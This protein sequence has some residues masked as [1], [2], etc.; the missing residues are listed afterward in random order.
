M[1][2][3]M[4][5]SSSLVSKV[6]HFSMTFRQLHQ[7]CK[8]LVV[9][10]GTAGC[11]MAAKLSQKFDKTPNHVIVIE[12]SEVHYY[13]PLFT[14]IGGG[15]KDLE[16]S[17]KSMKSVLPQKAQWIKDKVVC[18][19]PSENQV[20]TSNGDTI[21]YEYMIVAMGMDLYWDKL[22]GLQEA[23]KDPK[24]QVCSI[25]GAHTVSKVFDKIKNVKSG[26]ALFTFPNT[27][28]KCPGAPQKIVYLAEEFWSKNGKRKDVCIVYNTS[29]PVIFGVKKYADALWDVCKRRSINVNLRSNLIEI[30]PDRKEAVFEDLDNSDKKS[31]YE[32]SLLHVTPPMGTPVALKQNCEL[33]NASGFL[34][35]NPKTLQH[36][37]YNNIYGLGDCT[38]T[39]NS[40][41]M[42]AIASQSKVLYN[43]LMQRIAGEEMTWSYNGYASCPLVTGPGKCILA[44]F[45][46]NLTPTETF[47]FDQGKELYSMY[48]LKKDVFPFIYWN[49]MVKGNWNGP[50]AY[51]KLFS[52]LKSKDNVNSIINK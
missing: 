22:P 16:S 47:P 37:R 24:S 19:Q 2:S 41:T 33:T 17:R 13:Q 32:Y 5:S 52:L 1:Y 23:L 21:Q 40:K 49:L 18:F 39:P 29:L 45:D 10:G 36:I 8:I 3:T 27:P 31:T 6:Q 43:N 46:Y 20:K 12:P 35:V 42:A 44:E 11:A 7:C 9:G 4:R 28:V 38:T 14:L 51:R 50:E 26:N 30:R 48:L 34:E 25:Y 15:I